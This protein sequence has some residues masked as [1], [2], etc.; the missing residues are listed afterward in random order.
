MV[1]II[2]DK[3]STIDHVIYIKVFSDGTVYYLIVSIDDFLN[4]TNNETAS[5]ELARFFEEQFDMTFQE[6]SVLKYL[7]FRIFQY[8]LDFS[9][10]HTDHI[11][12]LIN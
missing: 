5:P 4:T 9:V 1:K 3:K 8:T 6:G 12:E 7:N 2:K 11:M 10:Y